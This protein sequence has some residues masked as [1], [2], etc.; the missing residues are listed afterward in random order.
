MTASEVEDP[1][2][3]GHSAFDAQN[4]LGVIGCILDDPDVTLPLIGDSLSPSLFFNPL[5]Q[6]ALWAIGEDLAAGIRPDIITVTNR[7]RSANR[8]EEV[9]GAHAVTQLIDPLK[10]CHAHNLQ[11][12]LGK[13]RDKAAQRW[14]MGARIQGATTEEIARDLE[15]KAATLREIGGE[16]RSAL[17]PMDDLADMFEEEIH[18]PPEVVEGLLHQGC[19]AV[20]GGGSKS[21]K[22]WILADM[23][24]SVATGAPWM[25]FPTKAGR[26]CYINLEIGRAFFHARMQ[27]LSDARGL[28]VN[29]G[30]FRPWNLRGHAADLSAIVPEII[31]QAE[32]ETFSLIVL[33]PIYKVLGGRDENAAGDIS[34]LLNEIERLAVKTG[35]AVVFGAHFSKGNQAGKESMDRIGGS[36]VYA[37]DPDTI[38]VLTKHEEEDAFTVET[39]LRNHPPVEPF[40]VRWQFP[41]MQRDGSLDPT[42]LKQVQGRRR[43]HEAGDALEILG[44]KQLTFGE[45][46]D[47]AKEHAGISE[48]TFKK[49]R[50]EL[51]ETGRV[52][53]SKLDQ[54]YQQV[55]K[56]NK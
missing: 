18:E 27:K 25:G 4:E 13:L 52:H 45:W 8:L 22:T 10:R 35:A 6:A 42:K 19:K 29:R 51:I 20:V 17:P 9:G 55:R 48:G 49:L 2:D 41:L 47:A 43:E 56:G 11:Y 40:V 37:R 3:V 38:L 7:L 30:R 21:F 14:A 44:E 54:K 24:L 15:S 36:G 5:A 26:V 33:D 31:R 16:R 50:K 23:A 12:E 39:T 34:G 46:R 28:K 1:S 53:H 32:A